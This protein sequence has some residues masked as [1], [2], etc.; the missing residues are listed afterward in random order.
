MHFPLYFIVQL[1]F[2]SAIA[3]HN[4]QHLDKYGRTTTPIAR[5]LSSP[6]APKDIPFGNTTAVSFP[7]CIIVLWCDLE[8]FDVLYVLNHDINW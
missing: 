4:T 2:L 3:R 7:C 6:A 8:F 1:V 5:E